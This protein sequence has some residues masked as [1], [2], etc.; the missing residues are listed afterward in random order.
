MYVVNPPNLVKRV[1]NENLIWEIPTKKKEVYLTFDDGP[2]KELTGWILN[3]L[4][5]FNA[6]ATFFC[7]GNNVRTYPEI[8][9]DI[10]QNGHSIGNHTFD[11]LNGWKVRTKEYLRNVIKCSDYVDTFLF[12]P[13]YAKIK[14]LQIEG[15]KNRFSI[16]LWSVMSYDYDQKISVDK[17]LDNVVNHSKRGSIIVFHDNVKAKENLM[18]TLPRFL[19][20]LSKKRYSFRALTNEVCQLK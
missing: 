5:Q 7:V 19:E 14:P 17:C 18:Y 3:T 20:H 10:I 12:R 1:L 8:Y 6:K 11:H 2:T 16:V 4:N 9:Q 13:P 15:L